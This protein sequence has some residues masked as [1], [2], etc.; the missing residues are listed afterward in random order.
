M[1][2]LTQKELSL[3]ELRLLAELRKMEHASSRARDT[4]AADLGDPTVGGD[5]IDASGRLSARENAAILAEHGSRAEN[6][7]RDALARL[8]S[9]PQEFGVC[10]SCGEDISAGRLDLLPW[11]VACARHAQ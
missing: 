7:A 1:S 9:H 3:I 6:A 4:M 8:R 10:L 5:F 2:R 11:T